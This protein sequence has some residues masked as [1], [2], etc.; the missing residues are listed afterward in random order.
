MFELNK[1]NINR[2]CWIVGFLVL[3]PM[4]LLLAID[5]I[6]IPLLDNV[7]APML[8]KL[9]IPLLALGGFLITAV[10]AKFGFD[11]VKDAFKD[12]KQKKYIE[13]VL[14]LFLGLIL[15]CPI[16]IGWYNLFSDAELMNE[17]IFGEPQIRRVYNWR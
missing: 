17:V 3:G 15:T 9:H 2:I 6:L 5:V 8:H 16:L 13:F 14:F 7:L 12:L 11:L 4:F 1:K 10:V